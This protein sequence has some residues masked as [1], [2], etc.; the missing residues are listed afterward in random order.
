MM[1]NAI[2]QT[3]PGTMPPTSRSEM[4][5]LAAQPN[6]IRGMEGGMMGPMVEDAAVM[7]AANSVSNPS[8]FMALISMVPRPAASATAEPLMPANT[9]DARI[10]TC[11]RPPG[12]QPTRALQELKMRFVMLPTFIILPASRKNGIASSVKLLTPAVIF[13]AIVPICTGPKPPE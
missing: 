8:S 1:P 13:C 5:T 7:P 4:D 6:M 9:T 10:F 3:T 11:P 2:A 12:I